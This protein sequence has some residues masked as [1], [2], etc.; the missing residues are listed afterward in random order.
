MNLLL[1]QPLI[2]AFPG[3]RVPVLCLFLK[4]PALPLYAFIALVFS[5]P[6][7]PLQPRSGLKPRAELGPLRKTILFIFGSGTRE[8]EEC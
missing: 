4:G 2:P 3:M 6:P 7:H 5:L 1:I 8:G